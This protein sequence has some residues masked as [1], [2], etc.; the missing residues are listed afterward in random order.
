MQRTEPKRVPEFC[1]VLKTQDGLCHNLFRYF[2]VQIIKARDKTDLWHS[3]RFLTG[4]D[5]VRHKVNKI[6]SHYSLFGECHSE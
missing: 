4:Q 2:S 3:G 5:N 6:E 1:R